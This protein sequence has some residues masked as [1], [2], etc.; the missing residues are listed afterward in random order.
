MIMAYIPGH[1]GIPFNER[2]DQLAG[3]AEPIGEL[4]REPADV[5]SNLKAQT[6]EMEIRRQSGYWSTTRLRE[7]NRK[8]GDGAKLKVRG[9]NRYLCNQMELGVLAKANLKKVIEG[10]GPE[11]LAGAITPLTP[12]R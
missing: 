4:S 3:D 1:C 10:G 11:R 5:M 12:D 6:I 8:Y 2:A 7:R 9:R